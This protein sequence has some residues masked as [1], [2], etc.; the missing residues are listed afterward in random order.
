[1]SVALCLLEILF[2][3]GLDEETLHSRSLGAKETAG[4]KRWELES[5][6]QIIQRRRKNG[7]SEKVKTGG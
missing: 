6:M 5:K 2:L 7:R 1:M 4:E 3:Q